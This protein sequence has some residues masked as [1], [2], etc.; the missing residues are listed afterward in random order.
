VYKL[1]YMYF[2]F[3]R[4]PSR[5]PTS[6]NMGQ[7]QSITTEKPMVENIGVGFGM[8]FLVYKLRYMY[9][10][11]GWPPSWVLTSGNM[12]QCST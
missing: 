10:R 1:R 12:G 11:F 2:R 6:G 3:R 4:P 5:V 9:F 7:V 8:V